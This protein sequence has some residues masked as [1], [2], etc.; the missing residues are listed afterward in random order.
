LLVVE[1]VH[2]E[3]QELVVMVVERQE[4]PDQIEMVK[5]E[6]EQVEHNLPAALLEPV[7]VLEQLVRHYKVVEEL[8]L[9]MVL[10]VAVVVTLVEAAAHLLD[11]ELVAVDQDSNMLLLSLMAY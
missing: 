8:H 7:E 5:I 4:M 10:P 3:I 6:V 2:Q 11:Q 1:E 9:E